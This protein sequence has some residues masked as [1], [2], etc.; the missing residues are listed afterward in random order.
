MVALPMTK[1]GAHEP[2]TAS[3]ANLRR[4]RSQAISGRIRDA[5]MPRASLHSI[6]Q[7][8]L[9]QRSRCLP[10]TAT[11]TRKKLDQYAMPSIAPGV[12]SQ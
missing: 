4:C 7:S 5:P 3:G 1:R 10:S 11:P 8:R 9:V 6:E 2:E 12:T